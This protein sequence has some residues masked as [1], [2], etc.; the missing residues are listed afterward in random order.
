[1]KSDIIL[2]RHRDLQNMTIRAKITI[3]KP[4]DPTVLDIMTD[5]RALPGIVTVRQTQ[6][7][8]EPLNSVEEP[9]IIELKVSYIPSYVKQGML[10]DDPKYVATTL[11]KVEGVHMIKI[12]GHDDASFNFRLQKKPIVI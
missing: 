5:M 3:D 12:V 11:K 9:R 10:S 1:M 7:V 6:P 2:E 4:D 8:S